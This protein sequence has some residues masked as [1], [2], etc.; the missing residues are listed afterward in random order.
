MMTSSLKWI[1]L[2][3]LLA[4][5]I[6][7][8]FGVPQQRKGGS[9]EELNEMAKKGGSTEDYM[10]QL[11]NLDPDEMMQMIQESMNDPAT[12]EYMEQFGEG[13]G[14]MME[15]FLNMDPEDMKETIQSNLAQMTSPETLKNVLQQKDEVLQSL[16]A[17]GLITAEQA[18]EFEDNPELFEAEMAKA[19]DEMN[20]IL[21]DPEALNAAMGMMQ[22]M[23]NLLQDPSEALKTIAEAFNSELGD[24]DK[25]EEARLQLLE[26]PEAAGNPAIANLFENADMQEILQDP[27]LWRE[28]VKKGQLMM[29]GVG[30]TAGYEEL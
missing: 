28:Q 10:E 19:F 25:I 21:A 12:A 20:K 7:A 9:F 16:L 22:G 11:M 3:S 8:Q 29:Q 14:E 30:G 2:A 18:A 4:S 13:M 5:P 27:L 23:T 26:N 6:N 24:N 17:E 15:Q 1:G